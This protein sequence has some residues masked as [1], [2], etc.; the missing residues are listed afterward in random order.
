MDP[1]TIAQALIALITNAPTIAADVG[2][3]YEKV[4]GL[5]SA[6]DQASVEA[7]LKDAQSSDAVATKEADTALTDASKV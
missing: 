4:K 3:I 2:A 1:L 6:D 7:A 5:L